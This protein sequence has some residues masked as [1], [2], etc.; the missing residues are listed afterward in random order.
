MKESLENLFE[1]TYQYFLNKENYSQENFRVSQNE[2]S[3]HLLYHSEIMSRV[4]TGEFFKLLVDYEV[5]Q[6]YAA[7]KIVIEKSLGTR[8]AK[9]T[10]EIDQNNQLMQY[11]FQTKQSTEKIQRNYSPK[12]FIVVPT[13]LTSALFTF[14]RK[15]DTS[16]R[17]A[18]T[19]ISS[20]NEWEFAGPPQDK[21]LFIEL[22][23][24][25]SDELAIAG[26]EMVCSQFEIF[27]EDSLSK[28]SK[29]SASLFVSKQ[30]GIPVKLVESQGTSILTTKFKKLKQ[31]VEKISF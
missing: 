15:I 12:H 23:A 4:E 11:S 25:N 8:W 29:N 26:T 17:T 31:E 27:E 10:Y 14:T 21:I 2:E 16:S 30:F 24:H 6:F 19:F 28:A 1:G 13:F 20:P 22:R 18:V 5:N 3:K 7:Q 9:E